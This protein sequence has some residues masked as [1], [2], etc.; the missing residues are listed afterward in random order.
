M[1]VEGGIHAIDQQAKLRAR[2]EML[3][4]HI[5]PS[6]QMWWKVHAIDQWVELG[7]KKKML[8]SHTCRSKQGRGGYMW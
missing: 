4:C 7:A 1:G 2:K 3:Q 8:Q 6:K 5:C